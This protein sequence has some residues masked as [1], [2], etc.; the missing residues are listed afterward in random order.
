MA[1]HGLTVDIVVFEALT[2]AGYASHALSFLQRQQ[3]LSHRACLGFHPY[4][5]RQSA[6]NPGHARVL[7]AAL[8]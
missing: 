4:A 3:G 7:T 6:F 2:A 8:E 5:L 1:Q